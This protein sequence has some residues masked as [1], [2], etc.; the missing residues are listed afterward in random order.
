MPRIEAVPVKG[1]LDGRMAWQH[2]LST[3]EELLNEEVVRNT[4]H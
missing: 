3:G 2:I 1:D 4:V